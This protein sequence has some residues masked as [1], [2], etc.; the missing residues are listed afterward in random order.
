MHDVEEL[1]GQMT[2]QEKVAMLAG[3]N[4]WYTVP[5]ERL[6]IPSLSSHWPSRVEE[7]R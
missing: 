2:V 7:D 5:V 3:T 1:L 6:G 4:M